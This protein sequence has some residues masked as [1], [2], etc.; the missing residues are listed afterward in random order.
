MAC[1][2]YNL[3][4]KTALSPLNFLYVRWPPIFNQILLYRHMSQSKW[5]KLSS[6]RSNLSRCTLGPMIQAVLSDRNFSTNPHISRDMQ[7]WP[8]SISTV[9]NPFYKWQRLHLVQTEQWSHK[10]KC[11]DLWGTLRG[12][13]RPELRLREVM[14]QERWINKTIA[15]RRKTLLLK[16]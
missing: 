3:I 16:K 2:V 9:D 11:G 6:L 14:Q 1:F 4:G 8:W 10:R 13:Y 12:G 15:G 7:C 5:K